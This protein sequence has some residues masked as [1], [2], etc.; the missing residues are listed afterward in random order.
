MK[1]HFGMRTPLNNSVEM[2]GDRVLKK[3]LC[4]KKKA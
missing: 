4:R 3:G 2:K 1:L